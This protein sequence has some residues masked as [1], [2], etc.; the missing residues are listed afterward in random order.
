[1]LVFILLLYCVINIVKIILI[2]IIMDVLIVFLIVIGKLFDEDW[3]DFKF[4]VVFEEKK[5]KEF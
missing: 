2:I 4:F 3:G 5:R 1:M